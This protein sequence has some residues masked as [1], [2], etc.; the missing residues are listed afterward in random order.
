MRLH[1]RQVSRPEAEE[2]LRR[3]QYGVL[4]LSAGDDYG[5][6]VPLSYVFQ[7]NSIYLH[8]APEG[9]KVALLRR[10]NKAC[11]CV[12]TEA[13]PLPHKFSMKYQSALA[14]GQVIEVTDQ[15]EKLTALL[16]LV[17]KYYHD[18]EDLAKGQEYAAASLDKILV[19][20]IDIDHLTGKVRK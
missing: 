1:Q 12:V 7:G 2:I 3:G 4:S 10:N 15:Q 13:E 20:R 5:Y 17:G 9:K 19:L 6:G 18:P 14:F 8:C 11:F 16:A